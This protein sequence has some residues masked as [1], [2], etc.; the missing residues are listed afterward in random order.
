[1]LGTREALEALEQL[2]ENG[3]V[4][5]G[6]IPI[7]WAS[8]QQAYGG[9]AVAPYLSM[10]ISGKDLGIPPKKAVDEASREKFL[11]AQPAAR[12]R[13]L[14][15]YLSKSLAGILKVPAESI[16]HD[17][18]ISKMGFDSL[19]SIELKNQMETDL[20][21]SISMARLLKGPTLVELT[22]TV[23]ELFE[24]VESPEETLAAAG[25]AGEFEEGVL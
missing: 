24:R 20:G 8:W 2:M 21:V 12:V 14:G 7:D 16:E 10:L 3:S 19:M 23:M 4:Q 25:V 22:E 18:P 11:A 1:M 13:L 15:E 17:L 5:A 9:L 6:V